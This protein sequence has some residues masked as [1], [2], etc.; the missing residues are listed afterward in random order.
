MRAKKE[1]KVYRI[2]TESEKQRYLKEG[3]DIYDE[4]GNVLIYSPLKKIA[5]SEYVKL[6]EENAAL[7]AEMQALQEN[8]EDGESDQTEVIG[9]LTAYA[10]EHDIN[11]GKATTIS[12]IVKKITDSKVGDV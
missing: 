9:I 6:K 3:Y 7:K 10:K 4:D 1:N 11:L 12:G 2:T 8:A 5:Y